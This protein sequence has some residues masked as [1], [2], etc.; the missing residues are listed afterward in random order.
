MAFQKN[1]PEKLLI[2]KGSPSQGELAAKPTERFAPPGNSIHQFPQL[3]LKFH[4]VVRTLGV[5]G[6]DGDA[7]RHKV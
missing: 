3:A 5:G 7:V 6:G 1:Q 2:S 4:A